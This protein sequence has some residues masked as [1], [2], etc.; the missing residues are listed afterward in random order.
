LVVIGGLAFTGCEARTTVVT[1][2][3]VP[4]EISAAHRST[5]RL[6]LQLTSALSFSQRLDVPGGQCPPVDA[7]GKFYETGMGSLE[8]A[9]RGFTF[10]RSAI[11]S[12]PEFCLAAWLD[13]N[14]NGRVDS[15]DAVGQ[16][17]QPYPT[18]PSKFFS[19][20]RYESPPVVLKLVP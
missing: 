16:L 20:N 14:R 3:E 8:E 10:R 12:V 5:D 6:R 15:G 1:A 7:A 19:S 11:P 13:V 9:P 17:A 4:P 18:Q 2:I